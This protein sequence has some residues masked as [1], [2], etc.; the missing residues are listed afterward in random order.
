MR[1]MQYSPARYRAE[2]TSVEGFVQQLACCYLR[3]GYWWY[4]CGWIPEGKDP[5]AVDLKLIEKYDIAVSE[6]TRAR[7]KK[8]GRANMQYIRC[9]RFFVLLATN[10]SHPFKG[11]EQS[12][13]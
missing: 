8:L 10:G 4:V 7:R 1:R 2:A 3:H 9:G 11:E 13:I 6:S 5:V 12:S